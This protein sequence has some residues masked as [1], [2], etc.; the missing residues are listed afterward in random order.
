[1]PVSAQEVKGCPD[2]L[3]GL[4]QSVNGLLE[5]DVFVFWH[6]LRIARGFDCRYACVSLIS[7]WEGVSG[8]EIV[9][10]V[11]GA[12]DTGQG[13]SRIAVAGAGGDSQPAPGAPGRS[14]TAGQRASR[15][16]VK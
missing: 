10:A 2:P 7:W 3:G 8:E 5:D 11:L 15:Y 16:F 13:G 1:M 6:A 4:A 9:G 12:F 14:R